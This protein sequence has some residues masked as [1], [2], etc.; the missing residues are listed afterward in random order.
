MPRETEIERRL[1][2]AL[3]L[4]QQKQA[5]QAAEVL[6]VID[7]KRQCDLHRVCALQPGRCVTQT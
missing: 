1:L 7:L 3:V 6:N 5:K 2:Y 4:I